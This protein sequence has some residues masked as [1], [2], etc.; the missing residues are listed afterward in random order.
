MRK[1]Y[2]PLKRYRMEGRIYNGSQLNLRMVQDL[3]AI[4]QRN[5]L[6]MFRYEVEYQRDLGWGNSHSKLVI[7]ANG[8]MTGRSF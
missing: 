5:A 4:N 2:R 8:R 6:E 3:Y 7:T 1:K